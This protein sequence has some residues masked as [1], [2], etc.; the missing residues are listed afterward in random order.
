MAANI[1][2]LRVLQYM[3]NIPV[4]VMRS[5]GVDTVSLLIGC[6]AD[7]FVHSS[8]WALCSVLC[9]FQLVHQHDSKR[10]SSPL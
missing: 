5:K 2:L 4:D 1:M 10:L 9:L 7:M 6:A 3:N 8:L